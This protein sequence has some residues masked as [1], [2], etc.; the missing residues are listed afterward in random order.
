VRSV[1]FI[2][3]G[4]AARSLGSAL[5]VSGWNVV[6][7]LGRGDDVAGAAMGVDVLVIATPD[8]AVAEV[9]KAIQSEPTTGVL[10]LSGSLG[11]EVLIDHPRRGKVHPLVPLPD[12]SIGCRRL[13][14]GVTFAVEGDQSA[15][16][17]AESLGGQTIV[18]SDANRSLYHAAACIASNHVVALLGQVERVAAT[19][20]LPLSAFIDL[21]R[22]AVE[23]VATVG[24]GRALTGPA[25]RGDWVTL[26]RHLEALEPD[27]RPSYQAGIDLA[28]R[29][30][31]S[32]R[33]P[34]DP[35]STETC[36]TCVK[37]S[38][39]DLRWSSALAEN[40]EG[41]GGLRD[42]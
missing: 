31:A 2:G 26:T 35:V 40:R 41:Y 23:D 12:A 27:E 13:L 22:W 19:A 14:E 11:L 37:N 33:V 30:K 39:E 16:E 32:A 17:V 7:F 8:G 20:G 9:A 38:D 34:V 15:T 36:D 29:L 24:P 6:E 18:V 4:R 3:Q 1:R 28:L 5:K 21:A 42:C 25:A 10:H